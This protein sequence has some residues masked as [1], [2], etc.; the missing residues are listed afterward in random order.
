M[1]KIGLNGFGFKQLLNIAQLNL[2]I[3]EMQND[4]LSHWSKIIRMAYQTAHIRLCY[5]RRRFSGCSS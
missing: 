1:M 4:I 2:Y 5:S 3:L